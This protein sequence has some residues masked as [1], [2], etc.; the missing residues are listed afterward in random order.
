MKM[1]NKILF[2]I[3]LVFIVLTSNTLIAQC[4]GGSGSGGNHSNHN[5][6]S[7][8]EHQGHKSG[9]QMFTVY[10][11]CDMCK[12]RIEQA[13][14]S[15]KGVKSATWDKE[16]K[17][18]HVYLKSGAKIDDVYMAVGNAGHDTDEFKVTDV[19]YDRLPECCKY[20]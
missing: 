15:V 8:E 5:S 10:G 14:L 18:L 7:A 16:T 3:C 2:V 4:H 13:A 1:K 11:K 12:A 6:T 20:R 9:M 19:K 17:Q